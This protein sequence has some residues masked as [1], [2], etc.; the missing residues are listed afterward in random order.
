M[1][2]PSRAT[3]SK[4]FMCDRPWHQ[5]FSCDKWT[6]QCDQLFKSKAHPYA[7]TP[8]HPTTKGESITQISS[9][10]SLFS[11]ICW[12]NKILPAWC[13]YTLR[14]RRF[15]LAGCCKC[16]L[17]IDVCRFIGCVVPND[18]FSSDVVSPLPAVPSLFPGEGSLRCF[19]LNTFF[20]IYKAV[21][22]TCKDTDM[23]FI[24]RTGKKTYSC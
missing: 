19:E 16:C 2:P 20:N 7:I 13:I 21:H 3:D 6:F 4:I 24:A 8:S 1:G 9:L 23:E 18:F 14:T 15:L 22:F 17:L 10:V 12:V 11:L 5:R